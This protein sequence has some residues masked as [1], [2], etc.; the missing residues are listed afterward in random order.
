MCPLRYIVFAVS[1]L[2]A[3]IV[4]IWGSGD[5]AEES[6]RKKLLA[7]E[8]SEGKAVEEAEPVKTSVF[9]FFNGKYLYRKWNQYR[10]ISATA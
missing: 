4:L 2:V 1:A 5:D 3:L 7:G 8:K 10:A 9:D 6:M